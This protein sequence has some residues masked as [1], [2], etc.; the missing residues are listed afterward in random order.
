MA[1]PSGSYLGDDL[2]S[3]QH[4]NDSHVGINMGSFEHLAGSSNTNTSSS[5]NYHPSSSASAVRSPHLSASTSS[6]NKYS[7]Q[8]LGPG[9]SYSSGGMGNLGFDSL[10]SRSSG[11]NSLSNYTSPRLSQASASAVSPNHSTLDRYTAASGLESG[12]GIAPSF[13][14]GLGRSLSMGHGPQRNQGY[15]ASTGSNLYSGVTQGSSSSQ[16]HGSVSYDSPNTL[17]AGSSESRRGSYILGSSPTDSH[18]QHA[19]SS[20]YTSLQSASLDP[21]SASRTATQSRRSS[22]ILNPSSNSQYQASSSGAPRS[23]AT[24]HD[25][26]MPNP[27]SP[28]NT[29]NPHRYSTSGRP[30]SNDGGASLMDLSHSHDGSRHSR[31]ASPNRLSI[32]RQGSG[33]QLSQQYD[34][35][36]LRGLGDTLPYAYSS[37]PQQGSGSS[38]G[39]ATHYLQSSNRASQ[40]PPP[41][42][43]TLNSVADAANYASA[44]STNSMPLDSQRNLVSSDR[45]SLGARASTNAGLASLRSTGLYGDYTSQI[46]DSASASVD[47]YNMSGSKSHSSSSRPRRVEGFRKVRDL[48][49]LRPVLDKSTAAATGAAAIND[50]KAA[51][52]AAKTTTRRADPAGGF[53]SVSYPSI[54]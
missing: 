9:P 6:A 32:N 34:A 40:G 26:L 47:K 4:A 46:S 37:H 33:Q 19:P 36:A 28:T 1:R 52:A 22:A 12:L 30:G 29:N 24:S 50:G 2:Q 11:A 10:E 45:T 15:R 49:D 5:S 43:T 18:S 51:T 35:Q 17:H 16:G 7:Q 38:S 14:D 48:D 20:P 53:V 31:N 42:S 13:R 25:T 21:S 27:Y 54:R 23:P 41:R 39:S 44:S 3:L 8:S